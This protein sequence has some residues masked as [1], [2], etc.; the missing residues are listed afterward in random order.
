MAGQ[1]VAQDF[2]GCALSGRTYISTTRMWEMFL[3]GYGGQILAD[4]LICWSVVPPTTPPLLA[5]FRDSLGV[6]RS[7]ADNAPSHDGSIA[8]D[9]QLIKVLYLDPGGL[10]GYIDEL[11]DRVDLIAGR[12]VDPRDDNMLKIGNDGRLAAL[13]MRLVTDPDQ[14]PL[15]HEPGK[16][17]IAAAELTR[18]WHTTKNQVYLDPATGQPSP[19]LGGL[20][21]VFC[22][23]STPSDQW[24]IYHE[25]RDQL[26]ANGLP[27]GSVRFI[28]D[29]TTDQAKARLFADARAG[30]IAVLIGSTAKMGTGTN[31]QD[32]ALHVMHLDAPWR[33]ADVTQREG[34]AIRQGNQ[35]TEIDRCQAP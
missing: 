22:D 9:R 11:A 4:D 16:V 23:L 17:D 21:I 30:K 19:I 3:H 6:L 31:V 29:A 10:A 15:L 13:D 28:H 24:N 35:N 34:R 1:P 18:I 32:R 27:P 2:Y 14:H 25:L 5:T 20:Q 7:Y 26:H 8:F 33:P 12:Q